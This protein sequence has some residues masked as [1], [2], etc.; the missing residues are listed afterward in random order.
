MSVAED[1]VKVLVQRVAR[2]L[3]SQPLASDT[4]EGIARWWLGVDWVDNE[5]ALLAALAWLQ[6]SGCIEG[7]RGPDG[8]VRYRQVQAGDTGARLEAIAQGRFEAPPPG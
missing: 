7:S 6:S 5:F 3:R 1:P 4:A 2:Y 8:R